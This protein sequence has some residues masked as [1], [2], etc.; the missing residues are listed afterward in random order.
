[1][2]IGDAVSILDDDLRGHI[3]SVKPNGYDVKD[4]FGF[5]YFFP[6]DKVLLLDKSL[7]DDIKVSVKKENT[8]P[9]SKKHKKEAFRIDLHFENL[10][11]N[12]HDYESFERL[13]IQREKLQES[14]EFCRKHKLKRMIIIHGIGDGV[15]Q[16][17]VYDVIRGL[18]DVEYDDDGFFYHQSGSI[19]LIFK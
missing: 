12:P 6:K 2:K 4:E 8:K 9:V 13:M 3:T 14:I 16:N 1:M 15:L 17:M 7:Y 19:E 11:K 10:V 18:A 5:V